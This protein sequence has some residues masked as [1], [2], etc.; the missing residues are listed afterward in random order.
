MKVVVGDIFAP[1]I[2]DKDVSIKETY[3]QGE[4]FVANIKDLILTDNKTNFEEGATGM[5]RNNQIGGHRSW[6]RKIPIAMTT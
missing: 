4:A 5:D 3:K 2:N 6:V 1:S